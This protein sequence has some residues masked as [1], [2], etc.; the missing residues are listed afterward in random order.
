MN[1]SLIDSIIFK[2]SY[3]TEKM[4]QCFNDN[5][6]IQSWLDV[7]AAL[8]RAQSKLGIIPEEAAREINS[9]AHYKNLD[10]KEMQKIYEK[11][12]HPIMPIIYTLKK[13]CVK[14]WGEY[15]HWGAT[16][17][18]IM[19]TGC[20]LQIR[21]A[22]PVIEEATNK[23]R[24]ICLNLA[25]EH[26]DTLL[27]GRT[28]GQQAVPI[29]FGYKAAIWVEEIKRHLERLQQCKPRLFIL[30]F[31]GAAGTLATIDQ[32]KALA[33]QKELAKELSLEVSSLPWHVSRDHLVEICSILA[34]IS[35]TCA[36]IAN[37]IV[38]LQRT[39]IAEVEQAQG[40]RIGSSTMPH[41]RNPMQFEHVVVLDRFIRNNANA[42]LENLLGEHERDW[43]TWGSEMKL[44]EENFLHTS[45][46]LEIMVQELN[47]L[48]VN[49]R[50]MQQ[51]LN[52]LNGLIM[53]E[54]VMMKLAEKLGRQ[55][56]HDLLHASTKRAFEENKAFAQI[57]KEDH[58]VKKVLNEREIDDLMDPS[59]YLGLA[60]KYVEELIERED[61]EA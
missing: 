61:K 18:D 43:R 42:M 19:D 49:R 29:T 55:T 26:R 28:H 11:S 48:K 23:L 38:A 35:G 47:G 34:Y 2:N 24:V 20:I 3:S 12:G 46:L 31:A 6:R 45:A 14:T 15:V 59:T 54:R 60:P 5:S 1:S 57:L 50:K 36:K 39:E 53:S 40:G 37:E 30:E 7:E 41:K 22:L 10:F 13:A 9:K 8:A 21:D 56:A 51:N 17:Q 52:I 58:R 16:T 44:I 27:S 32:E 4:R 25:R 33:L